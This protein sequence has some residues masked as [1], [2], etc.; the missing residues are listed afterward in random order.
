MFSSS[1]SS[2]IPPSPPISDFV[3]FDFLIIAFNFAF[4]RSL[5]VLN[6]SSSAWTWDKSSLSFWTSSLSEELSKKV[7]RS[8]G[9]AK[10]SSLSG[11]LIRASDTT[12]LRSPSASSVLIVRSDNSL[13]WASA[14]RT[15]ILFS[16]FALSAAVDCR[17]SRSP[18]ASF[19]TASNVCCV[20]SCL[21]S[22]SEVSTATSLYC[23]LSFPDIFSRRFS[24]TWNSWAIWSAAALPSRACWRSSR[25]LE[26]IW[27]KLTFSFPISSLSSLSS[28]N[29][30][31]NC[32]ASL[33][34]DNRSFSIVSALL[35]IWNI[36]PSCW[37]LV[38]LISVLYFSVVSSSSFSKFAMVLSFFST[39]NSYSWTTL[40]CSSLSWLHSL[41]LSLLWDTRSSIS[42]HKLAFSCL[43]SSTFFQAWS[44]SLSSAPTS[45][46][47]SCSR[48]F[49]SSICFSNCSIKLM[50]FSFSMFNCPT[51]PFNSLTIFSFWRTNAS[52]STRSSW[53]VFSLSI[54]SWR[55][56]SSWFC[57]LSR[58]LRS[59][60]PDSD[61]TL[62]F[63]MTVLNFAFS[64]SL[65]PFI[66]CISFFIFSSSTSPSLTGEAVS[67]LSTE[68]CTITSC[69]GLSAF[70][71]SISLIPLSPRAMS[72]F[73]LLCS[74]MTC[75]PLTLS[76]KSSL[77]FTVTAKA[78][79][80]SAT[81]RCAAS[82]ISEIMFSW[83]ADVPSVLSE[84]S[85]PDFRKFSSWTWNSCA[86]SSAAALP[87]SARWRSSRS[88]DMIWLKSLRSFSMSCFSRA[89]TW[90]WVFKLSISDLDWASS[91]S[92]LLVFSWL[93]ISSSWSFSSKSF[94]SFWRF[95]FSSCS[96]WWFSSI[97][98]SNSCICSSC[99]DCNCSSWFL[100]SSV[101]TFNTW[102]SSCNLP[103]FSCSCAIISSASFCFD[104]IRAASSL[105]FP[106]FSSIS[107]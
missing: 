11:D 69:K 83:C 40:S 81:S 54:F 103:S 16:R 5:T 101:V 13:S 79:L 39:R 62:F 78:A 9:E 48:A 107:G 30:L 27:S 18:S 106:S 100:F 65:S 105:I 87:S 90:S 70:S 7:G 17:A 53:Q 42:T 58:S 64:F 88:P 37:S 86:I 44:L 57:T 26:T 80:T 82:S 95:S 28:R 75:S 74:S 33:H 22:I 31:F 104:S 92:K 52:N 66:L 49:F 99:F 85:V 55:I 10:S 59:S 46:C 84:A 51:L 50:L 32:S 60:S 63:F 91:C 43:N 1:F 6:F 77:S 41:W 73:W 25:R 15:L 35:W 21:L 102:I 23:V 34:A 56:F 8:G 38:A 72:S 2:W 24:W 36:N 14:S 20:I 96:C 3:S 93:R 29:R 97:R 12:S 4:N 45:F 68:D 98:R 19:W 67:W 61:L 47:R 76:C 94:F 71:L 89:A